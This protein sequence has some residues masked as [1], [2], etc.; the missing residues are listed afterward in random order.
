METIEEIREGLE[1]V[2]AR[3]IYYFGQKKISC[4]SKRKIKVD[5]YFFELDTYWTKRLS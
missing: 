5:K 1:N 2:P 3:E 4:T